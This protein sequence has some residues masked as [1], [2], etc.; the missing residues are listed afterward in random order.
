MT[1]IDGI[2]I[3]TASNQ[4]GEAVMGRFDALGAFDGKASD[5]RGAVAL[6]E[7]YRL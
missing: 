5:A 1:S 3:V 6:S 4:I 2:I 7:E